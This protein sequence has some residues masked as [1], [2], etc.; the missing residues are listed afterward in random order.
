MLMPAALLRVETLKDM[1]MLVGLLL[2]VMYL[3]ISMQEVVLG[4]QDNEN[5]P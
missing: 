5:E 3:V 4:V 1:L 2:A